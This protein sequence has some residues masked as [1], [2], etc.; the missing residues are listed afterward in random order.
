MDKILIV[1]DSAFQRGWARNAL[2]GMPFE[3][4]EAKNGAEALEMMELHKP[5]LVISDLN[6]PVM[7]GFECLEVMR[8]R[9]MHYPV[10]VVTADIQETTKARCFEY[11]AKAVVHKPIDATNLK[12]VVGRVLAAIGV[13][14][15]A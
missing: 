7:G 4:V 10:M 5:V 6:M 11:G 1:D 9:G 13:A 2:A 14:H 12:N 8:S 3:L 15:E